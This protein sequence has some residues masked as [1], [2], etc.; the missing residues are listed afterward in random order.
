M[1]LAEYRALAEDAGFA[2]A[3]CDDLPE[4]AT[5]FIQ[6]IM[7]GRVAVDMSI[8]DRAN[9]VLTTVRGLV[10]RGVLSYGLLVVRFP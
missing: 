6:D 3:Q 9:G 8:V 1:S 7:L 4:T 2:V 5:K 10:Q